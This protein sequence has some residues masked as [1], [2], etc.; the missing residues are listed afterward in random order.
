MKCAS[1]VFKRH[2]DRSFETQ[3][4]DESQV[5]KVHVS[6]IFLSRSL[7]HSPTHTDTHTHTPTHPH[8]HT[9]TTHKLTLYISL[10]FQLT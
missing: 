9:P 7:S 2:V 3:H 1:L 4:L 5:K 8:T 10:P 6:L